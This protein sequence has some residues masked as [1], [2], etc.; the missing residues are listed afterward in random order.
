MEVSFQP[1]RGGSR[2]PINWKKIE[3]VHLEPPQSFGEISELLCVYR[4]FQSNTG[5]RSHTLLH[6]RAAGIGT[7]QEW[8][9]G[10]V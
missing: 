5:A 7:E 1:L 9:R 6:L 2:V 8:Q 4:P 10:W 3:A